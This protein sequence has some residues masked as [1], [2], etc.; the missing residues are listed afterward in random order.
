[1]KRRYWSNIKIEEDER[2]ES[3]L[4]VGIDSI[5]EA[6]RHYTLREALWHQTL[7]RIVYI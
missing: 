4:R 2:E 7:T 6:L 5:E 3:E 1:M